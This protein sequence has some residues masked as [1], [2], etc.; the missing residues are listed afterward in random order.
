MQ[1]IC[2]GRYEDFGDLVLSLYCVFARVVVVC[3][4]L[5]IVYLS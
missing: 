5:Y 3:S 4:C 2:L 1:G